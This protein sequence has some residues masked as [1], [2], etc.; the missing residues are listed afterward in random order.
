MSNIVSKTNKPTQDMG[1]TV[2][3]WER[4]LD[5]FHADAFPDGLKDGAR[6]G[7]RAEG[8]FALDHWGNRIGFVPD[9]TAEE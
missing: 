9:G 4:G 6:Q 3:S 2:E 5:P 1:G 7:K 8:W